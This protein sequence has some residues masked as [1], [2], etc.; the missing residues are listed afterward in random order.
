MPTYRH[1]KINIQQ[2]RSIPKQVYVVEHQ[3]LYEQ[4]DDEEHY[5]T[6]PV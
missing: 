2:G 4:Q 3:H 6:Y 5:V 1:G